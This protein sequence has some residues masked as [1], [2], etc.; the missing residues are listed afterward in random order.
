MS[1]FSSLS[2]IPPDKKKQDF[3]YSES[4]SS[5]DFSDTTI[6]SDEQK[7]L[8]INHV[9][10]HFRSRHSLSVS[11]KADKASK[12]YMTGICKQD[13]EY[14]Q[15]KLTTI[16]E[17]QNVN[18]YNVTGSENIS[19]YFLLDKSPK[20]YITF[21]YGNDTYNDVLETETDERLRCTEPG[22]DQIFECQRTLLQ[23]NPIHRLTKSDNQ[24]W[25]QK[26]YLYGKSVVPVITIVE[27]ITY[28]ALSFMSCSYE[29][30]V[31]NIDNFSAYQ[32]TAHTVR[33]RLI[34]RWN[35]TQQNLGLRMKDVL[36]E[37][38]DAALGNGGL[39]R[40]AA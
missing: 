17:S 12:T 33:D 32:A 3:V 28:I 31:Y 13:F 20:S 30:S 34:K 29:L 37:E 40:L 38:V 1:Y 18:E 5:P 15:K 2:I 16:L 4:S 35:D 25:I 10:H 14:I 26:F 39:G 8:I 7:N 24:S 11:R 9:P 19:P 27:E 21:S 22:C 36:D 6:S 23:H